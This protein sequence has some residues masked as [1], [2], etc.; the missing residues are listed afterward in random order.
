MEK[1]ISN[2]K[3]L[4]NKVKTNS[5][6][7]L[8]ELKLIDNQ[9]RSREELV[10]VFDNQVRVAEIKMVE[11]K[12]EV[13]QLKA[14][15]IQLRNSQEKKRKNKTYQVRAQ[16]VHGLHLNPNSYEKTYLIVRRFLCINSIRVCTRKT[17]LHQHCL[18]QSETRP[19]G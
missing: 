16:S 4:L 17:H 10:R 13:K 9:I 1:K 8:N 2:T 18:S 14:R 5:Q 12:Q 19:Y 7:S 11:K 15:L 6:A 3:A